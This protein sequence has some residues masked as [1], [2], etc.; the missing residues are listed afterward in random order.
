MRSIVV[1]AVVSVLAFCPVGK[2]DDKT[3]S[4]ATKML[5]GKWQ[6]TEG[7]V[8]GRP[9]PPAVAKGITLTIAD[10]K[11]FVMAENKDEGTVKY[12][13]DAS[14]K[15]LEITGTDG[16]NK[17]KTFPAIYKLDG[18]TLTV[19]YDLSG[20]ARPTEFK[21]KPGTALFLATYKKTKP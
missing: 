2:A 4:K 12:F 7:V 13:P 18:D 21:S 10:G 15:A 14:P 20:K 19:C 9:F 5:E 8:G 3:T 1:S 11:Y 16:P 17:G 6:M